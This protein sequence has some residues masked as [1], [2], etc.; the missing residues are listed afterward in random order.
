MYELFNDLVR[1]LNRMDVT[2]V[3]MIAI[4]FIVVGMFFLRGTMFRS[5]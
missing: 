3:C 5:K 2:D 4:F 1:Q